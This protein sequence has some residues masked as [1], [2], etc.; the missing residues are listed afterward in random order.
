MTDKKTIYFGVIPSCSNKLIKDTAELTRSDTFI[1]GF[2]RSFVSRSILSTSI[3]CSL[4]LFL[5]I[6]CKNLLGSKNILL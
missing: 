1:S 4:Q 3:G 2:H 5:L 6:R